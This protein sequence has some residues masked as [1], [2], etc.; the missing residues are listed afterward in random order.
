MLTFDDSILIGTSQ[1]KSIIFKD[2]AITLQAHKNRLGK[3]IK[4]K[5]IF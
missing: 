1:G 4:L 2:S 3:K 5:S